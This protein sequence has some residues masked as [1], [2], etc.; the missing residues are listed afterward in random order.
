MCR[1]VLIT[2]GRTSLW[3]EQLIAYMSIPEKS[4][5]VSSIL[6]DVAV[7]V[8]TAAEYLIVL[9]AK[10]LPVSSDERGLLH[11]YLWVITTDW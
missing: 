5:C 1:C 8:G 6:E 9:D 2:L 11:T 4:V 10:F 7:R 3:S